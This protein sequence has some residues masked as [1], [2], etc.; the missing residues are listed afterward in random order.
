MI[1]SIGTVTNEVTTT[2]EP[3][4]RLVGEFDLSN[5]EVLRAGLEEAAA[6]ATTMVIDAS[7]IGFID[8]S[9]ISVLLVFAERLGPVA[10][11]SPSSV[12]RRI[13]EA[14]GLVDVLKLEP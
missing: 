7:E 5:T 9:G 8:S 13:V 6:N 12:V 11:R 14:S 4:V 3:I 2:G 1:S 10:L